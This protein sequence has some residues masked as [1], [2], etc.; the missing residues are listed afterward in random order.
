MLAHSNGLLIPRLIIAFAWVYHGLVPKILHQAQ[1]EWHLASQFG[2]SEELTLWMVYAAGVAEVVFGV[3]FWF[4]SRQVW[5]NVL[6]I[7]AMIG[8]ILMVALLDWRYLFD[9]FN[10][11]TTNVPVI[12]CS[13]W[14]LF[15][16][17]ADQS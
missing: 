5:I 14:L 12:L 16:V 9:A 8:L 10:V 6:N 3:M 17:R 2:L 15:Q 13:V 11:I 7:I 4:L 1:I